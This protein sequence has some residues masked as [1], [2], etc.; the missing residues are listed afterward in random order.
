MGRKKRGR[1]LRGKG[2]DEGKNR[3]KQVSAGKVQWV[4]RRTVGKKLVLSLGGR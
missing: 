2:G 4:Q 3:L 1:K